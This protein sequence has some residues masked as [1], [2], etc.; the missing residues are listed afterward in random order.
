LSA[1]TLIV[2]Q[3]DQHRLGRS[4]SVRQGNDPVHQLSENLFT[5]FDLKNPITMSRHGDKQQRDFC[6]PSPL[7]VANIRTAGRADDSQLWKYFNTLA[8][9][10]Q[11]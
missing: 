4:I 6:Q 1:R 8:F 11:Q 5:H 2:P 7:V 10:P 9:A 3:L